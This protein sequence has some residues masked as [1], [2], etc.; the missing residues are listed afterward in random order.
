MKEEI[1]R[2]LFFTTHWG[3]VLHPYKKSMS[4]FLGGDELLAEFERIGHEN[5][6]GNE[7]I[8]Y[9]KFLRRVSERKD[10]AHY[11]LFRRRAGSEIYECVLCELKYIIE[12]MPVA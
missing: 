5:T 1:V 4:E 9:E 7:Q 12:E 3:Q 6:A 2:S 11:R 8:M 10:R